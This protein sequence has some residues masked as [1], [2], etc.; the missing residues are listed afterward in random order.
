MNS[1]RWKRIEEVYYSLLASPLGSRIALLE[2][3]CPE[4]A[5]IRREVESLLN[6]RE[7]AGKFLSQQD[8]REH[9][10]DLVSYPDLV[11]QTVG[12]YQLLDEIG[13]G[14]MGVVYRA[15]DSRLGRQVALKIL[16][17]HFPR[18]AA[19]V[20]RFRVEAK[21][22][23]A[24][25]H[26]N[27]ITIY[28]IGEDGDTWFIAAELIEGVTLRQKLKGG[29]LPLEEALSIAIQCAAALGAA[30]H[31]GIVHRDVKP[32]NIM[33][34]P[35][36]VV[37][38]V[39]FGLARM[40]EAPPE[41]IVD[42]TQAGTIMGTPRYMSPEQARG[43]KPDARSDIFSLG[44]VLFELVTG[45]PAFPG[46]TT[47]EVFAALLDSEPNFT[48]AGPF[49]TVLA[50]ALAK[51]TAVRYQTM[52]E[53][54]YDL[55]NIDLKRERRHAAGHTRAVRTALFHAGWRRAVW[56]LPVL[57]LAGYL[58]LG[59]P[60][61][62]APTD[63]NLKFTSLTV[64]GGSKA[65]P[66]FSPDGSRIAFSWRTSNTETYHIYIKPVDNSKSVQLTF[67]SEEDAFPTW[68]PD[69]RQI[70]FCRRTLSADERAAVP[71]GIYVVPAL[72]GAASKIAENCEGLSWSPDGKTLAVARLANGTPNSGGIDTLSLKSGKRMRLTT[73]RGDLLPAYSPN[74]K[75]LAFI[76]VL[77]GR[78]RGRDLFVI[79]ASGGHPRQLTFDSE[80]IT[81][82][83]WTSDSREIVFSSPRDRAQGAFW[84]IPVSGGTPRPLSPALRNASFPSISREGSRMA[85]TESWSD[86]NIYLR[87]SSGSPHAG[88][89][90][91][92]DPP[93]GVALSTGSDHSPVFSPD[94]E[95]F[96]FTSD[97]TGSNQIWVSR[98]DGSDATQ[99]TSLGN[100]SAGSPRWSP[101]GAWI[102]FD[103]WAANQSKI[104]VVS[105]HGGPPRRVSLEPGEGWNP[106]WSPD[107]Q[108]IYFTS[109]R[110]GESEIWKMPATGGAPIQVTHTGAY[111]GRASLDGKTVYF[112]KST[113][114]DCC[115]I[116]SV[117]T[118][119]GREEPVRALERFKTISRSWGVLKNGIYFIARQN[120]PRQTVRFLSFATHQVSD[121]VSLDREP[122][123]S[124][125]GLAMSPD[126]RYL[127]TV[128]LDREAD[129]LIMIEN[130]R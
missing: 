27:I 60:E 91:R 63:A 50:K 58:W 86:S 21:A 105:S 36:G 116:W 52:E 98:R 73:S 117:P 110:S 22:A 124:F 31:A 83:T 111:E 24:L 118:G 128:Q 121:V 56:L 84:R 90:W 123:W 119:G 29:K 8:F 9:I 112:R 25:N 5:D 94:G 77:P 12:P 57:A 7:Q 74:G 15:R 35:D 68:S 38:V 122:D 76:R 46:T 114:R 39:D 1:E 28:E 16:P 96:A 127:L 97:R 4:D 115:A 17:A 88:T 53:F 101:D 6:A 95:R 3:V 126:E 71:S 10:A 82:A 32:E 70:A 54:A 81:G 40:L 125:L 102:A 13:I 49:Q 44:A 69:G 23:S 43:E 45:R 42:A 11:G 113:P 2:E 30:H 18:N 80:Y 109:D 89:P 47:A 87:T 75:W 107:G 108:W 14:A 34:R 129:D 78:G 67:G 93:V 100:Q 55:R 79:P 19:R 33:L 65:Y 26:P 72:G 62:P 92:F 103:V 99:L 51:D 85:F 120:Q 41:W 106:A 130:F 64:F 20:A 48:E 59:R 37:K 104:Y 66:A 61:P